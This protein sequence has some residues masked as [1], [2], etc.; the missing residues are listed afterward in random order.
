MPVDANTIPSTRAR[1]A[2]Y[3]GYIVSYAM[4]IK[5]L[6]SGGWTPDILPFWPYS[7]IKKEGVEQ[8]KI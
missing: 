8:V 5:E 1:A 6:L 2:Q 4:K 7:T 3:A